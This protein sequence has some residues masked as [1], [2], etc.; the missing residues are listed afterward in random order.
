MCA[1][2]RPSEVRGVDDPLWARGVILLA[3]EEAGVEIHE[4]S[5]AEIKKAV[6]GAGA[7]TKTQVQQMV[8]TLLRLKSPPQPNDAAD[9]VAA[10][11]TCAM[12]L[13]TERALAGARGIGPLLTSRKAR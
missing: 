1:V 6:V 9:G 13:G 10:A 4:Y 12:R 3:G 11:L 2:R 5:P 8:A 7:A